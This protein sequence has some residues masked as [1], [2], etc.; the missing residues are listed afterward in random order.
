MATFYDTQ[1]IRYRLI[2]TNGGKPY[3]WLFI[4]GGPGADSSYFLTLTSLV[5]FP[6]NVWFIDLPGMGDH[7]ADEHYNFDTWFD[8]FL[9]MVKQFENPIVVGHSFGG[10]FPLLYPELENLLKGYIILNS[11]PSLWLEEAVHYGKQFKLPDLSREVAE[12]TQNPSQETCRVALDACMPYYFPP[13]TLELGRQMVAQFSF[14]FKPAVWWQ[15]VAISTQFSAKWIPK[16]VPTLI[17][18][19]TYDCICPYTLFRND[20]RFKRPNIHQVHID[21]GGHF[22]WIEN[23]EKVVQALTH[24]Y[25]EI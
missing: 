3:N 9:P 8:I 1:Q 5:D 24:F 19:A 17:I 25:G 20:P 6:G 23:P 18:G 10:M 22:P 4:P 14:N 2:S 16:K 7:P 11:A 12:F 13:Q 21:E 15:R